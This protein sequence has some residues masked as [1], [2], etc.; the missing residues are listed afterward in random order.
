MGLKDR[1]QRAGEDAVKRPA[2]VAPPK[3]RA[4][5]LSEPLAPKPVAPSPAPVAEPRPAPAQRSPPAASPSPAVAAQPPSP[6][7]ASPPPAPAKASRPPAAAPV[8]KAPSAHRL[9]PPMPQPA[10]TE[11]VDLEAMQVSSGELSLSDSGSSP[12][13][14][15]APQKPLSPLGD[16]DLAAE[17]AAAS[18]GPS[19][20]E[21]PAAKEPVRAP[22]KPKPEPQ[23]NKG[24]RTWAFDADRD[25]GKSIDIVSGYLL[26]YIDK[27][28][29][30]LEFKLKGKEERKVSLG[31]DK[32]ETVEVESPDG[33]LSIKLTNKGLN[34]EGNMEIMVE[35]EGGK[36]KG[37]KTV[38]KAKEK[39]SSAGKWTLS[40]LV[41]HNAEV[42]ALA[43]GSVAPPLMWYAV[44]GQQLREA[45]GPVLYY[46]G[47]AGVAVASAALAVW[48]WIGRR[49]DIREEVA[50]TQK[51]TNGQ[52]VN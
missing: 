9:P 8:P 42:T 45:A 46:I 40:G 5:V 39:A 22:P 1:V 7:R 15:Q 2:S 49:K 6:A 14:P 24:S 3:P 11:E 51:G 18:A 29:G 20:K 23:L 41:R 47:G 36:S 31:L 43:I 21:E 19:G 32:T 26:R 30:M 25:E 44:G 33:P 17:L 10:R 38:E 27:S 35:W 16:I 37:A 28:P 12:A 13:S 34:P 50:S 48:Q 4:E 52:K